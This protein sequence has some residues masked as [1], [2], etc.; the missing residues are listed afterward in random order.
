MDP[1][2]LE[3]FAEEA[4]EIIDALEEGLLSL[5][6]RPDPETINTVFR[7]AH[8]MKGNAGIV[9]FDDVMELTHL[10]EG[11]L[12][13][14]RQ[15]AREPKGP[16]MGLL[17]RA[18]DQLKGM[19]EARLAGG[20][21]A[22]PDELLRELAPLV[23]PEESQAPAQEPPASP[24][25]GQA[26][27]AAPP[28]R[29]RV[30]LKIR[31]PGDLFTTGTDPLQL[32][33]ELE[34]LGELER[35]VC[36][37]EDL[38][39]FSRL[40]PFNLHLWWELW[41]LTSHPLSTLDNVFIFVRDE[42]EIS[43]S[44]GAPPPPA[45][46][47]SPS[48]LARR[49]P[50]PPARGSLPKRPP[51]PL[52]TPAPTIRVDTDK[53]VNLVGEMVIGLARVSESIGENTDP[54]LQSAM[55]SMGQI[56]REMQQQ[57]MRVRMVPV[58]GTFNRFRRMVRD[59]AAELGKDIRLELSGLKTELDKN[60]AEQMADPLKHLVRNAAGHGLETPAERR[61]AN[62][63][64]EG[65]IWLRAF[66]QEG[67]I[68]LEVT[69]DGRGIDS[70]Q[71][72]AK[73]EALGLLPPDAHLSQE[74]TYQLLFHPGFTTVREVTELSGRGVGLDVVRENIE[75]LRGSVEVESVPGQG[76]TF[77]LRL[78][79]TLAIID[80]MNVKVAGEVFVL[81]MLA[82]VES[83]RPTPGQLKTVEGKGEL[84]KLRENYLPLVRLSRLFGLEG[85]V[86]DPAEGLVMIIGSLGKS[87]G[88]LVDDILGEQ[89][90][91]IKSLEQNYRKV[92][93]ISGATI[94]GD[95][96]VGLI[97]DIPGLEKMALAA[98]GR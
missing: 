53:L 54:D 36:H 64:A 10:M 74:E 4:R 37:M 76:T 75:S 68:F 7:A 35:V 18:T 94:L 69:D 40:D 5:E 38:P 43:M 92:P 73:A 97:L 12:D 46:T 62:K 83:L 55:E 48:P 96:R 91:V 31:L 93:G 70:R 95:G 59:L 19:V 86:E 13:Q 90:A 72:R 27:P 8:T 29:R 51:R 79:L 84:I 15:G 45:A 6:D 56:S 98:G 32:L 16:V 20:P 82:I 67:R 61:A 23:A 33:L 2:L 22:P 71:V 28:Q 47:V 34:E 30:H 88:L 11:V 21:A 58:E 60:V 25:P 24:A 50:A 26:S 66:Q 77:R 14:M 42:A 44:E 52:A 1:Q 49:E 17:L 81:P 39:P 89:Q 65:T 85:G 80:G 57:V 87:F 3:I 63:P 41:L 9:G 78:P